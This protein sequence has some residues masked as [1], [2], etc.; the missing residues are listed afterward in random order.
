MTSPVGT[1]LPRFPRTLAPCAESRLPFPFARYTKRGKAP[2]ALPH[3]ESAHARCPLRGS[4]LVFEEVAQ[5]FIDIAQCHRRRLPTGG[6]RLGARALV[7][8]ARP[9][10]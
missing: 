5:D 4:S 9:L 2:C 10:R 8:A 1:A 6:A 3:C 7:P